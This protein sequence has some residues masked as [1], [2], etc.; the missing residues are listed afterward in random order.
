MMN[1]IHANTHA[2][3]TRTNKGIAIDTHGEEEKEKH[4]IKTI[5]NVWY[6]L[7]CMR[8]DKYMCN[9]VHLLLILLDGHIHE[10]MWF[11][12]GNIWCIGLSCAQCAGICI[13]HPSN[14]LALA[15][16][17]ALSPPLCVPAA[18]FLFIHIYF[19]L[20]FNPINSRDFNCVQNS[21]MQKI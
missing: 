12:L 15:L 9:Q 10:P 13:Y 14:M 4:F 8:I 1:E 7:Q 5:M 11:S 19:D 16:A 20:L 21:A 6:G 18:V 3:H 2:Q 17:L